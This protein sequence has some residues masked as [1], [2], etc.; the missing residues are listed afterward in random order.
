MRQVLR[1]SGR[2]VA[3]AISTLVSGPDRDHTQAPTRSPTQLRPR[4]YATGRA[5]AAASAMRVSADFRLF[6]RMFEY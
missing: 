4:G 5:R 6:D 1:G 2:T 3:A